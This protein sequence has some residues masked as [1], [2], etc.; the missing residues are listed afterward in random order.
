M[1][2]KAFDALSK[3]SDVSSVPQTAQSQVNQDDEDRK[4]LLAAR[5]NLIRFG[6]LAVL[7]FVVWLFATIA[8]FSMNKSVTAG[9]GTVALATSD[10][11]I[12]VSGTNKGVLSYTQ[13]GIGQAATYTSQEIY[14]MA[15][16][17]SYLKGLTEGVNSS[18]D[19]YDTNDANSKIKWRLSGTPDEK[20]LGPDSQGELTF[21]VVPKRS[22]ELDPTFSLRLE[23]YVAADQ[24]KNENG[25]YQVMQNKITPITSSSAA[26]AQE[27]VMHLN[28]HI[29]FFKNRTG[30]GT[31]AS[32]Y[33][34]SGLLDKDSIELMDIVD[35]SLL[36]NGTLNATVDTPIDATI[37]WI[38][39]NT[40]GQMVFDSTENSGRNPVGGT[41]EA[42]TEI[43]NYILDNPLAV[44]EESVFGFDDGTTDA[45]KKTAIRNML[46]T[47][48][49][50][51]YAFSAST[52]NSGTN[53]A[54]LTLGYNSADQK[55]GTNVNYVLLVLSLK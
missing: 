14:N 36:T 31:S 50:G 48:S 34:Y 43:Q 15:P 19:D 20:G 30:E 8:W 47:S 28:G 42:R 16:T 38:W 11:E 49:G 44:F 33:M 5:K 6:S 35:P 3:S 39:P 7:A 17:D 29:L 23:G 46:A 21:K 18:D 37:Y 52:V 25:S 51:T 32:P 45:A 26:E 4:K 22:G 10:F 55:I 13:S 12:R 27:G 54:T 9:G 2:A 40:F 24:K 1:S 53:L 41:S